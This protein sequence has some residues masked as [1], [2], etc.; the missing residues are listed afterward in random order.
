MLELDLEQ[1]KRTPQ[2]FLKKSVRELVLLVAKA[3]DNSV[4]QV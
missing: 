1:S 4:Q 3:V 2:L